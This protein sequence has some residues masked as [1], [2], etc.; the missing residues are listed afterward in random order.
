MKTILM[1]LA[2]S[3]FR[4]NEERVI[5]VV[6]NW[7]IWATQKYGKD[8]IW[9]AN[10]GTTLERINRCVNYGT[11]AVQETMTAMKNDG[12]M[13]E[14][15]AAKVHAASKRVIEAWS[16]GKPTPKVA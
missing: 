11:V 15:E 13:D 2:L 5:A 9:R 4:N 7:L 16:E 8:P 10:M 12:K 3:F 1:N 14:A 6:F